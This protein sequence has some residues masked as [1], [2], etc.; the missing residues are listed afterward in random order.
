MIKD[1]LTIEIFAKILAPP[2]SNRRARQLCI[3]YKK[4]L[5]CFKLGKNWL[6]P[7]DFTDPRKFQ[8][9]TN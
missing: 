9:K 2:V 5:K 4:K 1:Y 7:K 8:T 3:M 6:I